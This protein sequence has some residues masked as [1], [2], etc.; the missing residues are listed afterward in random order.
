MIPLKLTTKEETFLVDYATEL[1]DGADKDTEEY[2]RKLVVWDDLYECRTKPKTF[3]WP[4]ASN[5]LIPL[6]PISV[7]TIQP[8][9]VGTM[10][11]NDPYVY[12]RPRMK[13]VQ[14]LSEDL[15][16]FEQ[17]YFDEQLN[18]FE[19]LTD[20]THY[21][22]K[23]GTVVLKNIWVEERKPRIFY[24]NKGRI[25]RTDVVTFRGP[26]WYLVPLDH[27][28]IPYNTKDL[29][30]T[31]FV[32]HHVDRRLPEIQA[33]EK[34]KIYREGFADSIKAYQVN[35]L[36]QTS[37]RVEENQEQAMG[38]KNTSPW[39]FNPFRLTELYITYDVKNEGEIPILLTF[40]REAK[41]VARL[42]YHP[43]FN[44]LRPFMSG[45]YISRPN[46]FFG[47]GVAEALSQLT[48]EVSTIHNQ[49]VDSATIA[50]VKCFKA[51]K[52]RG[53]NAN[54]RA[55]PGKIFFLDDLDD[56]QEFMLGEVKASS[57][58]LSEEVSLLAEKRSGVNDYTLGRESGVLK[59]RATARGTLALISEGNRNLDLK[60]RSMRQLLAEGTKQNIELHQQFEPEGREWIKGKEVFQQLFPPYDVRRRMAFQCSAPD[61]AMNKQVEQEVNQVLMQQAGGIYDKLIQFVQIATSPQTP[62]ALQ[63]LA[64]QSAK[65]YHALIEKT[66]RSFNITE[67]E[68]YLPNVSEVLNGTTPLINGRASEPGRTD[69]LG[70]MANVVRPSLGG[71]NPPSGPASPQQPIVGRIPSTTG[72]P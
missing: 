41:K 53:I 22:V 9:I 40:S 58:R 2:K 46:Q 59:S 36:A 38:L 63:Q 34:R 27:L 30:T 39:L 28:T 42:T 72:Q 3:P 60:L 5:V 26:K 20:A 47:I 19:V 44:G 12:I 18:L 51:K 43:Q 8:R 23:N 1:L 25:T 35:T 48:E 4:G 70:W 29:Q 11:S 31:H 17:F 24:D 16:N 15:Q 56:L 69:M 67:V 14:E 45:T 21:L 37:E 65:S 49:T 61:S 57:F 52:G 64:M 33:Q 68:R 54:E 6:V 55:Y 66:L 32:G 50:N 13:E 62:P 10:L 7:D 71:V